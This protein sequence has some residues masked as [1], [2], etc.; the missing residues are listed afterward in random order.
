M[1]I[2]SNSPKLY[3]GFNP[4]NASPEYTRAGVYGKCVS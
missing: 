2:H 4:L 3:Y 1:E